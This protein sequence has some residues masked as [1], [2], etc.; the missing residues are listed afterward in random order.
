MENNEWH[1]FFDW[2]GYWPHMVRDEPRDPPA[3]RAVSNAVE[4]ALGWHVTGVRAFDEGLNAVYRVE[5]DND[6]PVVVKTATFAS[7]EQLLVEATLLS[8][9]ANETDVPFP[10][11]FATL[12]PGASPLGIA[13]FVMEYCEGRGVTNILDLST[14]GQDRLIAESGRHLAAVHDARIVD[15]FGPLRLTGDCLLPNPRYESWN[16]WFR[17]LVD[18]ALSRL[19]GKGFTTDATPRFADLDTETR[20]AL[21]TATTRGNWEADPAILFGDYRPANLVLASDDRVD[22]IIRAV[23][24]IGCGPATDGLLDLALAEDALVD[25]PFG[26]TE[27]A[28]YLRDRLRASYSARRNADISTFDSDRYTAYRLYAR[29]RRMGTFGYWVQFAHEADQDATARRWRSF[30]RD[31]LRELG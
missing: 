23:I 13:A 5:R 16:T 6:S 17:E 24:D 21:L 28:D 2:L 31:L 10:S 20:E 3:C 1:C 4:A 14:G 22:P 19:Q 26:G 8:R 27:R 11:V 9:L 18:R 29:I 12:K 7:D 30:A 25:I 15:G